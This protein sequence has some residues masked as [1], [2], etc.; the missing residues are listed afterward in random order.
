M[1]LLVV[2][3]RVLVKYASGNGGDIEASGVAMGGIGW[4]G[5]DNAFLVRSG[6]VGCGLGCGCCLWYA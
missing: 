3:D 2:P 6:W 1:Y 4:C 5:L